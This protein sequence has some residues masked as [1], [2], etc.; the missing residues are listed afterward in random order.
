MKFIQGEDRRQA[1]LFPQSLDS[2]IDE[3][4]QVRVIDTF[5]NSLDLEGFGFRVNYSENGRPAYHPSVLLKLFIYGYMNRTRSSRQLEKECHRNIEVMWL[6][7]KLSPDHNTISNF[8][9]DNP[10]AIK[11]V[12]KATVSLATHYKLIGGK[13]IAG[14]S[15][16]F[17]SQNSK[18][19]NYNE[20]KIKRHIEHIENKLEQYNN[21]L[22]EADG[23]QEKQDIEKKIEDC[24]ERKTNYNQMREQLEQSGE[25]QLS[26]S[27]PDSRNITIRNNIIEVCYSVQSTVDAKYCIPIDFEVTNQNDSRAMASIV[28]RATRI[29]HH[30]KFRALFDK[31]YHNGAGLKKCEELGVFTIVAPP[32]RSTATKAQHPDYYFKNF[33]YRTKTDSYT[34]PQNQSLT[35]TGNWYKTQT[36]VRFK[37]YKS[38]SCRTCKAK[39][40]CTRAKYG[41]VIHRSEYEAYYQTNRKRAKA[42][43]ELYKRRQAIV[44]H[45]FGTMKRQWG[46]DHILTKRGIK[47]ASA[48]VGLIYIA[49]NLKRIIARIGG[50]LLKS[51]FL[52]TDLLN[53]LINDLYKSKMSFVNQLNKVVNKKHIILYKALKRLILSQKSRL[54]LG[55]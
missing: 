40:L 16:K 11:G 26:T 25:K 34:C 52:K 30:R 27:D 10:D 13:L 3:N 48:D 39:E 23:D 20:K 21:E 28:E 47:R 15:S 19:N 50:E 17:R 9:R 37:Q 38:K 14:D 35:S 29:L 41:R 31:G 33:V 5:V 8:R 55:Y 36:G 22:E 4:N 2:F 32:N 1:A 42:H 18:K 6:M 51:K 7:N 49:Y 53:L 54:V 24:N 46:F 43:H 12:F 45:P 44:E